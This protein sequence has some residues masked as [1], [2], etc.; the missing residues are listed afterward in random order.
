[1]HSMR[2]Y[3]VALFALAHCW[4]CSLWWIPQI[5]DLQVASVQRVDM[6][7]E[8]IFNPLNSP[9]AVPTGQMLKIQFTTFS[10]LALISL[11]HD[12]NLWNEATFCESGANM[13]GP[14]AVY[15]HDVHVSQLQENSPEYSRYIKYRTEEKAD[16]RYV[17]H[18][19]VRHRS[20]Q[21]RSLTNNYRI[22]VYDLSGEPQD[23]CIVIRGGNMLGGTLRT[24]TITI[25]KDKIREALR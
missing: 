17:Y 25:T 21:A 4:G 19:Y 5:D 15:Y 7:N 8:R 11:E 22:S 10:D 9:L 14:P 16:N 1:M 18:V 2:K 6:G 20:D 13:S 3:L 23:I 24:N 12:L